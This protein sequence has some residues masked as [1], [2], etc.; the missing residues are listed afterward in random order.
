MDVEELLADLTLEERTSLLAGSDLW[1]LPPVPRLGIGSLKMTDGPNGARGER[2]AGGPPSACFPC[3]TALAATWDTDLVGR[4]GEALGHEARSK[5]AHVLLAPTVNLHRSPL[6]GRDFECFSEDP[7]LSA[8]MAVAYVSGVQRTGVAACVKHL[9]AN[10]AEFERFTISSDV[11]E[12]TLRELYLVPFE[13]A[14]LEAG[15]WAVM[16]AYNRL[17]GTHCSQHEGLLTEL[18]RDEW[19]WDGAV[20]SDW[21]GSHT[22]TEG[23]VAGL[24]VEMPGPPLH[25]GQKLLDELGAT[26]SGAD[27]R[28]ARESVER[29]TRR[30]LRLA[31]RTGA[32]DGAR[33]EE[34][35]D[36]DPERRALLR[37]AAAASIVVLRNEGAALPLDRAA[38][39]TL[40]VIGPN[41][42]RLHALGGGSAHVSAPYLVTALAG[43]RSAVGDGVDIAFEPGCPPATAAAPLAVNR[44]AEPG[45]GIE[46][47]ANRDLAGAPS[48]T[49]ISRRPLLV[50]LGGT[51]PHPAVEPGNWSVRATARYRPADAGVHAVTIRA[52]GQVRLRV[53]GETVI[54]G[55][56]G[57][58]RHRLQGTV[59]LMADTEHEF[60]L[61]FVPPVDAG[62]MIVADLRLEPPADPGQLARA[63]GAAASSS[64]A[65][66]VVGLD[67]DTETEGHDRPGFAL[68]AA[69]VE[70]IEQV[71]AANPR[72]IVVVNAA[73]PVAMDWADRVAAVVQLW[74]PGQEGGNALADVLFGAVNPS[75]RLPT[76][77]PVRNEDTPA[78]LTWPGESGHAVYGEGVFIGYR[79]YEKRR[80]SPRFAFGHGLSYTTFDYGE[81]VLA[82]DRIGP[83][84][85]VRATVTVTNSGT[86]AG[87]EVVQVYVRDVE[88]SVMRPE[89]ELKA[90]ARVHLEPGQTSV[91]PFLLDERALSFWDTKSKRWRAEPGQFEILVGGSSVDIRSRASFVLWDG[92]QP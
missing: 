69:Q 71:A 75:G 51:A 48:G 79:A 82:A 89:K 37:E 21:W 72:T 80:L 30:V 54:D 70:L 36:D 14:L 76:T 44:L 12:R 27:A 90:F 92:E 32:L 66:V 86:C 34:G 25:R 45:I 78:Y 65:V 7:Y 33:V 11:D 58:H 40:A 64:A 10:D 68:P 77:F 9:V 47:F 35:Y 67:S 18:L 5:G 4:I 88:A 38:V 55:W 74:C 2:M 19:G 24:D 29:A 83:G 41:A 87:A 43:L 8:R 6:G 85:D 16:S 17:N 91:I 49:D 62:P 3:G 59:D 61:D 13:A 39:A 57:A 23:L 52:R 53:D 1:H 46:Y 20:I 63:V 73:S 22:T 81:V 28:V 31:E 42:D 15:A 56:D 26:G 60:A 50:W 84:D